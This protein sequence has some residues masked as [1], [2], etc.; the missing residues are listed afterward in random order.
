MQKLRNWAGN[1]TYSA[2]ELFEPERMEQLQE[3]VAAQHKVKALGSR[4]SFN[5][6]ADTSGGLISLGKMNRVLELDPSRGTVTVEG[7]IRYGELAGYL[8]ANRYALHNLASLPHITI[9]GACATGTHGSGDRNGNLATVVRS[10]EMVTASGE[11]VVYTRGEQ[12]EADGAIVN[13]GALGIVSKLT[14]DIVPSFDISQ[15]VFESLPLSRLEGHIDDVFSSAYSV[16]LFTDWTGRRFTQVW[17]KQIASTDEAF[18]RDEFYG[19]T[20]A[21]VPLHPVPGISAEPC[22]EQLGKRGPWHERLPHFRMAF[23]PSAGE[24]LQSEY[25][26]PRNH[27]Y[28]ALEAIFQ[29][30]EHIA[31]HLYISEVRSIAADQLWMS[32]NYGRDSIGIHF[33]WKPHSEAVE[34]VLPLIEAALEP[35]EARPHWSKLFTMAPE[36]VK[37]LYEKHRDFQNLAA[38]CDPQGKFR[39]SFLDRYF[40]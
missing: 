31:P 21:A 3:W 11:A 34:R 40:K 4:H 1:Y 8:H 37:S 10:V 24:E 38:S 25:F 20:R 39:N 5:S 9:A 35:Y 6:I 18:V 30:E 12:P 33:T 23:T 26:V 15:L 28:A 22:S 27:A 2:A 19:A 16:S 36:R 17:L 14:L 13:L 7:G 32:P 29:L